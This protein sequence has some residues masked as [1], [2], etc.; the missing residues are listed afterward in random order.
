MSPHPV[1][2][3]RPGLEMLNSLDGG[4]ARGVKDPAEGRRKWPGQRWQKGA[5]AHTLSPPLSPV[6]PALGYLSPGF[7]SHPFLPLPQFTMP[8]LCLEKLG[9]RQARRGGRTCLLPTSERPAL[10]QAWTPVLPTRL[11][12]GT[13]AWPSSQVGKRRLQRLLTC[14]TSHSSTWKNRAWDLDLG[15]CTVFS[16]LWAHCIGQ[17]GYRF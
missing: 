17:A 16:S 7:S 8:G 11:E 13:R 3:H 6:H 5:K 12:G 4:R 14:P 1:Q 10:C 15:G 2:C 9:G